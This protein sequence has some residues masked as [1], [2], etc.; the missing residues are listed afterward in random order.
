[1]KRFNRISVSK[2]AVSAL[3]LGFVAS[4]LVAM[5]QDAEVAPDSTADVMQPD[6]DEARQLGVVYVSA[7]K[8]D[9]REIDVPVAISA[10]P[11]VELEQRGLSNLTE[12]ATAV[13]EL[14]IA[15][16]TIGYGGNLTMRGVSSA[17][18]TASVEQ[19]V[20]V[21]IDGIPVSYAGIVKLGQFDLGQ[22]EVLKGP[23][24]LFFGKN[25]TAGIVS[26]VS[27]QPTET[28]DYRLRGEYEF[29]SEQY[30]GEAFVSG[31][32]SEGVLGRLAVRYSDA[33]GWLANEVPSPSVKPGA[34]P[35][36]NNT[37]PASEEFLAKGSLYIEPSSAFLVKLIGGYAE[38][39]TDGNYL[40][41]Q[42]IYCPYGNPQGPF[43]FAGQD[44]SANDV[45]TSADLP[46]AWAN[47]DSRFPSDG[48]PYTR[49]K[50]QLL[51][52][53]VDYQITDDLEFNSIT[54]FYNVN[55]DASD[56][57][58]NGAV[59]FIGFASSI[60]KTTYSQE[61]RLSN[62]ANNR[63]SWMI[64]AFLQDDEYLEDQSTVVGVLRPSAD[65]RITGDTFSPFVQLGFDLTDKLSITGGVRYSDETK[66]QQI[67]NGQFEGLYP[68]EI[69]F[70]NWSPEAT[71]SYA[72]TPNANVYFA[73]KEAYKSGGFQ[74]EHVA[75]PA[76][77]AAGT[78]LDNSFKEEQVEGFEVGGKAYLLDQSLRV[79]A[80]AYQFEYTDLQL[81]SFDSVLVATII[82]N[83]GAATSEGAE[84]D[85]EYRPV[86]LDGFR[87]NGALAYNNSTFDEYAPS[88]YNGQTAA[89]GC[90][91]ATDTND[92]SGE[93][94][95]RAPEWSAALSG[96]YE[97]SLSPGLDYRING[98]LQYSGEYEGNSDVIPNSSQDSYV[99]F[100]AG[101]ALMDKDRVWELALIGRNLSE[102]YWVASSYQVPA[103]GSDT[104]LSDIGG[105]VSRGRQLMLRLTYHPQ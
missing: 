82:S 19:A 47:L 76:A 77:L 21:N 34:V 97:G 92:V 36:K 39:E 71:L 30:A 12:I 27:A 52:A 80:A 45:T 2:S 1:M 53:D 90:D 33:E 14:K 104:V 100:D 78:K 40:T 81:G 20:T 57:V 18:S 79:S 51:I 91:V 17:T 10:L 63:F 15:E 6:E 44:C 25:S 105:T 31:P 75:I 95:P 48:V 67:G 61:F 54:G 43:A 49:T 16:N 50:Q 11:A 87:L 26:L 62:D 98:G 65:F 102:E 56:H 69:S 99:T 85:F 38:T 42:R 29:E 35:P 28:F 60:E 41:S 59:P 96:A 13:P 70:E 22:V 5:A 8:R 84:V 86:A 24:A 94:L 93:H 4:D 103:T 68:T 46:P 37:G 101:F 55:L 7:R 83:V 58:S 74:T 23:Q 9:E 3:A 66:Q 72:V 73:Y 88:C 89:L 32:L 64:G